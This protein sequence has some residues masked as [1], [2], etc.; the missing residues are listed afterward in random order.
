[1]SGIGDGSITFEDG[2][3]NDSLGRYSNGVYY[4]SEGKKQ[5]SKK[6]SKDYY[7]LVANYIAGKLGKSKEY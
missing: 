2:R 7:G 6:K 3:F 4:D 5:T 1:M